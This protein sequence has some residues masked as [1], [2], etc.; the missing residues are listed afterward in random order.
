MKRANAFKLMG[1]ALLLPLLFSFVFAQT[2][3]EPIGLQKIREYNNQYLLDFSVTIS[4]FI[5]FVAGIL[6]ILSPCILPILPAYFSIT[7]KEKKNITLMTLVFFLGFS[8]VF[9]AMG[10]VA[11]FIGEQTILAI[12]SPVVVTIGGLFLIFMGF[13]T[14]SGRGFGSFIRIQ[15]RFSND[16][17]GVFLSGSAFALGWTACLGPILAA[18]LGLGAL[19]HNILFSALLMFFYALGNLAPLFI[20]SMFYDR[21]NLSQSRFLQGRTFNFEIGARLIKIHSTNLIAGII[22]VLLGAI[23]IVFQGTGVFNT[24]DFLGTKQYFYSLQDWLIA[25]APANVVSFV[26]FAIFMLVLALFFMFRAKH[27]GVRK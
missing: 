20:I 24:W 23:I 17:P 21:L 5:A 26:L 7:F 1:V 13:I 14:L 25:W 2:T 19:L 9:V 4:F 8:L 10:V 27:R 22:F 15:K 6:A 11:G 3:D 16:I 12:Q 18:I